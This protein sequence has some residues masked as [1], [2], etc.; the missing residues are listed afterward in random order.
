MVKVTLLQPGAR[1]NYAMA[2]FLQETGLLQRFYTDWAVGDHSGLALTR[3][4][5]LSAK[6]TSKIERRRAYGIPAS[7]ISNKFARRLDNRVGIRLPW[8]ISAE[9]AQKTDVYYTQYYCGAF[10]LRRKLPRSCAIISDVF[11]VPST[12]KIVNAEIDRFPEWAEL[13]Y[14]PEVC[15]GMDLFND[16]M[17]ADSDWLFCPAQ[18][19]IDDIA[20]SHPNAMSKC[21]L[22]PYGS[23]LQFDGASNPVAKRVLFAGSLTLRK[24]PQYLKQAADLIWREDPEVVFVFAGSVSDAARACMEGPNIQLL[25]QLSRDDMK[26]EYLRADVMAFPSLAEGSAGTTLEALAAG[27]P[28]IT[29]RSAGVDFVEGE[30]GLYVPERD[31]D[32]LVGA[33]LKVVNDRPFRDHLSNGAVLA[34]EAY[35]LDIW[36]SNYI[37]AIQAVIE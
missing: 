9:D 27:V 30:A 31:V 18:S 5:P 7:K 4:L 29:T 14:A 3:H 13:R 33:I 34:A 36:K 12:H 22:V 24:G 16:Q 23:S 21:R 19:V 11:T 26:A 37:E 2:R 25:G 1:H 15:E 17:M 10:G 6:W 28:L 8:N 35:N 32:A 20:R